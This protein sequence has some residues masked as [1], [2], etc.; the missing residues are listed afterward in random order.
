MSTL[1]IFR[2]EPDQQVSRLIQAIGRGET[3]QI[4][5]YEEAVDYDLLI[6]ELFSHDRVIAWW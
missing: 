1:H 3:L 5:L 6:D 2:S 4:A